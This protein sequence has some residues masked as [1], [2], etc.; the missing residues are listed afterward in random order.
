M[1]R[2]ISR[3]S[4]FNRALADFAAK[5]H[6]LSNTAVDGRSYVLVEEL[7]KWM[8][9]VSPSK[10]DNKYVTHTDLLA[11]AAYFNRSHFPPI[12]S[13]RISDVG[14]DCCVIVFSILLDLELGHLIDLFSKKGIV[15]SQLPQDLS[16]LRRKLIS[17]QDGEHVPERFNQRQWKFCPAIF[18]LNME[19]EYFEDEIIPICRKAH[20]N[21]GGTARVWQIVVQSEFVDKKLRNLLAGDA[22]AS[23]VDKDYGPVSRPAPPSISIMSTPGLAREIGH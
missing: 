7:Q 19:R 22:D 1:E 3:R 11:H 4:T 14:P 20:L 9:G 6:E 2:V 18:S 23:Y 16:S 21:S 10:L 8:R 17:L 15:D 5:A 12:V 13:S